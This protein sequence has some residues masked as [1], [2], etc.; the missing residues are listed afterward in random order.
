MT[1]NQSRAGDKIV[2]ILVASDNLARVFA[3]CSRA[4]DRARID[5][6][7]RVSSERAA[8]IDRL[9]RELA[10]SQ[11]ALADRDEQIRRYEA[12]LRRNTRQSSVQSG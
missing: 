3:M 11:N 6:L 10:D 8:H 12:A 1:Q 4:S 9:D 2:P 7:L 5:F